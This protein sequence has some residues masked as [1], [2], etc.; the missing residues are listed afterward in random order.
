MLFLSVSF[1]KFRVLFRRVDAGTGVFDLCD[2]YI[3]TIFD[4]TQLFELFQ[5]F[6]KVSA[7]AL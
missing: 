1:D 7:A 4:S 5:F 2:K 6:P 3:E